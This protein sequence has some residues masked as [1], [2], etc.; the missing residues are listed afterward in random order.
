MKPSAPE[1]PRLATVLKDTPPA[2]SA[3]P[4]VAML[5][6][7]ISQELHP[8]IALVL[9][10]LEEMLQHARLLPKKDRE[11]LILAHRSGQRLLDLAER[12][13]AYAGT[14]SPTSAESPVAANKRLHEESETLKTLNRLGRSLGSTLD[15]KEL[16][17]RT[18]DA[19]T[20]LTGAQFGAFFYNV[21]DAAGEAYMLYTLSGAPPE[22]FKDFPMPRPTGTFAPTFR[23]QGTVRLDDVTKDE[24]YGKN[25]PYHGMPKGHLPVR[26]YLAVP[27]ISRSGEVIGGLFFGHGQPGIFTERAERIA[28]GIAAQ[29]AI[30]IDNARL[31]ERIADSEEQFRTLANSIPQMAWMADA[32]G[33][34]VWFNQRWYDHTGSSFDDMKGWGWQKMLHPDYLASAMKRYREVLESGQPW[35]DTFPLR[36]GDGTYRWFLSRAFPIRDSQGKIARWFGTHTDINQQREAE[37][38]LRQT[39][40]QAEA[41][42]HA[43]SEFLANMSHEI[44]TPMNA[45]VGL[46]NL[47]S[48]SEPLTDKQ[49]QFIV[50]LRSSSDHLLEIINDLLDFARIE[51]GAVELEELDFDLHA[52]MEKIARIM[53]VKAHEKG[54]TLEVSYE[55]ELP[56]RFVGDSLR[57]QQI[58]TNLVSN[59]IKFTEQGGVIISVSGTRREKMTEMLLSINDTGIGIPPDKLQF[60][61]EKFTQADASTTRKYGGSG[62][63]LSICKSLAQLMKGSLA[64]ESVPGHGSTFLVRLPLRNAVMP[65]A[66]LLPAISESPPV[67]LRDHCILLVEDYEPNIMV[68]TA[69][70][71]HV[72]HRYD[73]ARN[74]FEALKKFQDG[75]YSLILMDI[76]MQGMDGLDTTRQIRAI[77]KTDGLVHT[78]IVAMT[79][80]ATDADRDRC[81]QAG[82]DDYIPK[83]FNPGEFERKLRYHIEVAETL[84]SG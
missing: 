2:R 53:Q 68:A 56:R 18:T 31:Y 49:R 42:N 38:F 52:L 25:P 62:L 34:I 21:T 55:E 11:N 22:A 75:H 9:E 50:T 82:M 3:D 57:I 39:K 24:R 77:E 12:L 10:P 26:S 35:E 20:T 14:F 59:A 46:A 33:A 61:F 4:A 43:K 76:Q 16:I 66:E 40:E 32:S 64:V 15:L 84:T 54:L 6:A 23:G 13:P 74:G 30:G 72:G 60:I 44:R 8:F 71:E 17:Q 37:D 19:A 65:E 28:E 63:G 67:S 80:H 70:I 7:Q 69:M 36:K 29:A 58:V 83:P 48:A 47:L 81:L 79:A 73:V 27:V 45:V 41:A 78:P 5:L 51:Q 1:E